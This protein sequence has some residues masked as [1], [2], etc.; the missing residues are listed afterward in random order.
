MSSNVRIAVAGA[1]RIGQAHIQRIIA[2]PQASLAA[3]IDPSPQAREQA[4][5]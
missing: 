4:A 1:G 3:I 5:A 2:E